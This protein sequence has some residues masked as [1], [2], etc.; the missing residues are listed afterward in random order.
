MRVF[1]VRD[2]EAIVK[3]WLEVDPF[4]PNELKALTS[5]CPEPELKPFDQTKEEI[6]A[7]GFFE[8]LPYSHMSY[9]THEISFFKHATDAINKLFTCKVDANTLV[10][11]SNNEHENVIK[12]AKAYENVYV[13]DF[14]TEIMP[15]K[16]DK[17][18]D[19][20]RK[21][22]K[23]FVYVIGT[24]VSNGIIT[25]QLF[26]E[27]LKDWLVANYKEH[28]MVIDDVHGLFIVPR[29]YEIFDYIVYTCHALTTMF[30]LG[31]LIAKRPSMLV[32]WH[33]NNMGMAY[34][35]ALNAVLNHPV[36]FYSFKPIMCQYFAEEIASGKLTLNANTAPHIFAPEIHGLHLNKTEFD[37]IFMELKKYDMRIEAGF[38]EEGECISRIYFRVREGQYFTYP[39]KL[40]PGLEIVKSILDMIE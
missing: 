8:K 31:I 10:V 37:Q 39:E 11:I 40:L 21:Y 3:E 25:P 38:N 22:K 28:T 18:Y 1:S 33:F 26:F 12:A 35:E 14:D 32:G 2:R 17:L 20:C 27:E 30:D 34:L 7:N 23:V 29:N 24:Q 9:N 16:L 19:E 6:M 15:C 4:K 5:V 36:K 13:L